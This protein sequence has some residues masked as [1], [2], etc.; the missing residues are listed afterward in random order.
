MNLQDFVRSLDKAELHL[1]LE[2]SVDPQTI[3]ELDSS[4]SLDEINANFHYKGFAG[5]L[6]SYVWVSKRLNSP[7]A[8]ALATRRLLAKLAA[9]NVRDMRRSL[10]LS[11][12]SFGNSRRWN[13]SFEAIQAEAAASQ[14]VRGR[15]GFSMPFASSEPM[16]RARYLIWP[17]NTR[18]KASLLSALEETKSAARLSGS[19]S[20]IAKPRL[21]V[22]ALPATP[23]N[24]T[25]RKA[26]GKPCASGP[27][28]LV[29][30]FVRWKIR[31]C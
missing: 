14:S 28:A 20:F 23:E 31:N 13:P 18:A 5:F 19:N 12:S 27:S 22:W 2:G 15:A 8:Y 21:R 11:A 25:A 26:F 10:F 6:K 16:T 9:Q 7:E 24:R 17:R 4:L 30:A 1:H 29:M 3:H